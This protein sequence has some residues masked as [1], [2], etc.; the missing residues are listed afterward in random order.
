MI[1]SSDSCILL[2]RIYAHSPL[3]GSIEDHEEKDIDKS[4]IW[5]KWVYIMVEKECRCGKESQN[6]Q[7]VSKF[8]IL[9]TRSMEYQPK[10]I[11]PGLFHIPEDG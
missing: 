8:Y 1:A 6:G 2:R 7:F 10:T 9:A 3:C 11:A 5:A 4:T